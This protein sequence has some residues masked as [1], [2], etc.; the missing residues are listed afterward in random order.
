MWIQF[1]SK[2]PSDKN[3]SNE[4]RGTLT[5]KIELSVSSLKCLPQG[6]QN[7]D[8]NPT[9]T[10]SGLTVTELTLFR[11]NGIGTISLRESLVCPSTNL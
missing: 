9:L 1:Y 4:R 2:P 3:Y 11:L 8:K 5:L 6:I 10:K 7:L